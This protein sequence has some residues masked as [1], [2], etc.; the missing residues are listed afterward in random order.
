MRNLQDC[1]TVAAL[2]LATTAANAQSNKCVDPDGKIT[3]QR[4]A[5]PRYESSGPSRPAPAAD[6]ASMEKCAG[7]WETYADGMKR[8]RQQ[9]ERQRQGSGGEMSKAEKKEKQGLDELAARFLPA[10]G[11]FGFEA[12]TEPRAE[13]RNNTV[14]KDLR[15]KTGTK[16]LSK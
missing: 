4:E 11:R 5:C 14:A 16:A 15:R 13:V 12:P 6:A 9:A 10:C 7:D 1:I 2:L 8:A 3:Y